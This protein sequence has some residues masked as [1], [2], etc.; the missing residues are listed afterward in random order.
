MQFL[1]S[2]YSTMHRIKSRPYIK[3]LRHHSLPNSDSGN[4]TENFNGL[5]LILRYS[6][7]K[8]GK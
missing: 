4:S 2:I 8:N 5:C 1:S 3:N 7:S 6:H